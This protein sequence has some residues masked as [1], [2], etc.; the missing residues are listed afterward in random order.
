MK[1]HTG[2]VPRLLSMQ[3]LAER[4][5]VSSKT[6][7]R[8]IASGDLRAHRLGRQIRIAEEDANVF[9]ASRRR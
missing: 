1:K 4:L 3:D 2:P 5:S 6:I 8:W 7:S 9:V